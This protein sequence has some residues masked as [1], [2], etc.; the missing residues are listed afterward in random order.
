MVITTPTLRIS[1]D[2]RA[3]D[4]YTI[5]A[6]QYWP[7]GYIEFS[8]TTYDSLQPKLEQEDSEMYQRRRYR[9]LRNLKKRYGQCSFTC[10]HQDCEQKRRRSYQFYLSS[11]KQLSS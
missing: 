9:T 5:W 7:Q 1:E 10:S 3:M 2:V 8:M 6:S 4:Q 11:Q